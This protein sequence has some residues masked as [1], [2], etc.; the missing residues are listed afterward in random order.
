MSLIQY[1]GTW[2]G[3]F[4]TYGSNELTNH[5]SFT[6]TYGNYWKITYDASVSGLNFAS[7]L[8]GGGSFVT[9]SNLTAVPEP[10][11]LFAIGC[12]IGSGALLRSRRRAA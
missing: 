10:G 3:G 12:L 1:A 11:S 2:N 7:Q 8:P 6:D 9:L 4:F 5:E